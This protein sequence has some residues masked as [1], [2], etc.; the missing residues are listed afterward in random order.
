MQWCLTKTPFQLPKKHHINLIWGNVIFTKDL[1]W[2]EVKAL[3]RLDLSVM[4]TADAQ[5]WKW[6][7][8]SLWDGGEGNTVGSDQWERN[9]M[10]ING[11]WV[12]KLWTS[13]C[14]PSKFGAEGAKAAS[15]G[16]ESQVQNMLEVHSLHRYSYCD[17]SNDML[18]L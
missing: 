10:P 14:Q 11:L 15:V 1:N 9:Q 2:I 17:V 3:L 7:L 4:T 5:Q 18:I 16:K 8:R 6:R 12:E 13:E